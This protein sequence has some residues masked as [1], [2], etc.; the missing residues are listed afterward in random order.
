[1]EN[2]EPQ[3]VAGGEL[4][5]TV[6][7]VSRQ[8]RRRQQFESPKKAWIPILVVVIVALLGISYSRNVG[9]PSLRTVPTSLSF[10]PSL[11]LAGS[12]ET[13]AV[14][15]RGA[16]GVL[17]ADSVL[18][19]GHAGDFDVFGTC[20]GQTLGPGQSCSVDVQ[21]S[22]TDAGERRAALTLTD[23][24]GNWLAS[25]PL[26]ASV[27]AEPM[28]PPEPDTV[29][30]LEGAP[31]L[32]A[33]PPALDFG[34]WPLGDEG[35]PLAIRLE[36]SGSIPL[37]I[38][39]LTV[40]NSPEE[41]FAVHPEA[42]ASAR[43]PPGE[44]CEVSVAFIPQ[45]RGTRSARLR[46]SSSAPGGPR[47]VL[48]SGVGVRQSSR[49]PPK[50]IRQVRP[51]A[52]PEDVGLVKLEATIR[53]D[54]S[55]QVDGV[56][57]GAPS[58]H[59]KAAAAVQQWKYEPGVISGQPSDWPL[60]VCVAFEPAQCPPLE[61]ELLQDEPP[62]DPTPDAPPR[63]SYIVPPRLIELIEPQ[64]VPGES[65]VV[66]LQATIGIDGS[67]SVGEVLSGPEGLRENA[68]AAAEQWRYEAGT[69]GGEPRP[70]GLRIGV[71]FK[72]GR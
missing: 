63:V 42:C 2:A 53:I 50:L 65:G 59:E 52:S 49:V 17:I 32:F 58:L 33:N 22:P 27:I 12:T 19:G 64:S 39:E 47:S 37:D 14:T 72:P 28:S 13:V 66:A 4:V 21:F 23:L 68:V 62:S 41:D 57:E 31:A 29:P 9:A 69:V 38:E 5:F 3:K 55:V 20:K 24:S 43:L 35:E 11:G 44:G 6:A 30:P 51:D 71:D 54:G 25:V 8:R 15:N 60:E 45:R 26:S 70:W 67:V 1:M 10:A 48:L 16:A 61:G 36:N 40:E 7:G 46:I 18:T 56:I 34:R